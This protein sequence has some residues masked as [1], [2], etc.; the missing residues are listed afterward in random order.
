MD[1]ELQDENMNEQC[2]TCK[3]DVVPGEPAHVDHKGDVY[4]KSCWEQWDH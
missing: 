3:K 4:H 1:E 2:P